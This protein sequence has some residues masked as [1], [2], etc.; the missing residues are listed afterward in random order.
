MNHIFNKTEL[1]ACVLTNPL[2]KKNYDFHY[3]CQ[4]EATAVRISVCVDRQC[5]RLDHLKKVDVVRHIGLYQHGEIGDVHSDW[6]M[7]AYSG[8]QTGS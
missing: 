6:M 3:L 1:V 5:Q 4:I 8:C 2:N 7:W